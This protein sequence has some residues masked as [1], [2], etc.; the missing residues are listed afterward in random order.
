MIKESTQFKQ[1]L[2]IDEQFPEVKLKEALQALDTNVAQVRSNMIDE[3]KASLLEEIIEEGLQAQ[4]TSKFGGAGSKE[5]NQETFSLFSSKKA[6]S[7][8]KKGGESSQQRNRYDGVSENA[9]PYKCQKEFQS[10]EKARNDR[11]FQKID[12][13]L[14]ASLILESSQFMGAHH[15]SFNNGADG[16]PIKRFN[17]F[18]CV[19]QKE[20]PSFN[21]IEST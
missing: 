14:L 21:R 8:H 1:F 11:S 10:Q 9:T 17:E 12:Q 19:S 20:I 18:E 3:K 16:F 7:S 2:G 4:G 5:N 15:N 6:Q 13:N